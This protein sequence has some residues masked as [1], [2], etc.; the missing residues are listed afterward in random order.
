M[1]ARATELI[2]DCSKATVWPQQTAKRERERP[3][4]V[5]VWQAS[6]GGSVAAKKRL[7]SERARERERD[8]PAD[9]V[10]TRPADCSAAPIER[11]ALK[12]VYAAAATCGVFRSRA[13]PDSAAIIPTAPLCSCAAARRMA[14]TNRGNMAPGALPARRAAPQRLA[15]ALHYQRQSS[16]CGIPPIDVAQCPAGRRRRAAGWRRRRKTEPP[17]WGLSRES[18]GRFSGA[19]RADLVR[20][21]W[22]RSV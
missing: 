8:R 22:P 13:R 5:C 12:R 1:F 20:R 21:V 7:A 9:C 15:A 3:V 17:K 2:S 16:L 18:G 14:R 11:N 6:G 10:R 4:C 19:T